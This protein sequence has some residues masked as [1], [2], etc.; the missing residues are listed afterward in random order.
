MGNFFAF[1]RMI[2]PVIIQ[3]FFW[4]GVVGCILGGL[5]MIGVGLLSLSGRDAANGILTILS[6]LGLI[7]L[8]PLVV[9]IYCEIMIVLFRI[10]ETL[11]DISQSLAKQN[12]AAPR[13]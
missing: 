3:I 6:G 4:I 12:Q 9:R 13:T 5:G 11:T 7:F 8:G 10:N 2:T 1:K